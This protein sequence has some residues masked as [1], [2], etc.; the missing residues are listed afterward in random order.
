MTPRELIRPALAT[1]VAAGAVG[2]ALWFFGL[3]W[4]FAVAAGALVIAGVVAW[5]AHNGSEPALYPV[6]RAEQRPGTRSELVQTA[7]ALRP[8]HGEIG[9]AG[10]KRVRAFARRRLARNGWDLDDAAAAPAIRRAVGD[11]AWSVLAGANTTRMTDVEHCL[12]VLE[13]FETTG[14]QHP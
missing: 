8:R 1:L 3:T 6:V 12:D 9:D 13:A 2:G 10:I 5:T 4:P 14:E 7:W 11:R